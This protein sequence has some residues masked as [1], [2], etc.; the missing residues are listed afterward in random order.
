VT[1]SVA[2]CPGVKI[3]PDETPPAVYPAPETVTFEIVT[4][5]FPPLVMI[6]GRT[7]LLPT[8]TVEKFRLVLLALRMCVAVPGG[9]GWL[10]GVLDAPV[11]PV[12]PE[13][14]R[15]ARSKAARV[16]AGTAFWP[17]E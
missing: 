10:G 8:P 6:T 2:V 11:A 14:D 12:Q 16:A 7:L 5:E 4:S 15:I 17:V 3:R 9:A 13:I 1:F